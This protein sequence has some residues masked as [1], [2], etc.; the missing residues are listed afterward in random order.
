MSYLKFSDLPGDVDLEAIPIAGDGEK[1]KK[2]AEQQT[3][4]KG[5][6][7]RA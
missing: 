7:E 4:E 1:Q 3:G 5:W 6:L 2:C